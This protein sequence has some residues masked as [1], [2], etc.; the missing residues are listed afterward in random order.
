MMDWKSNKN[1]EMWQEAP[2]SKINGSDETERSE[3]EKGTEA[4]K[5]EIEDAKKA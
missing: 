2:E 5:A 1:G 3:G 4:E